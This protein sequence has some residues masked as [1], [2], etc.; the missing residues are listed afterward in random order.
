MVSEGEIFLNSQNLQCDWRLQIADGGIV[1]GLLNSTIAMADQ[2]AIMIGGGELR[3]FGDGTNN[4]KI[5]HESGYYAFNCY[6]GT[7]AADHVT[8]EYMNTNGVYIYNN[9]LI[10]NSSSL[11][12]C[13]FQN[14]EP[15]GTLLRLN[16]SQS[17]TIENADFPTNSWGSNYN[18]TK[19]TSAGEITLLYA[20][21]DFSGEGF[22]NDPN[23]L[24]NWEIPGFDLD[25][26]IY[27][28]G[29][30]HNGLMNFDL[31]SEIPL[32]QPYNISPWNYSGSESVSV[33]PGKTVDWVLVEL[34]DAP[35]AAL[36]TSGT[37]I[38]RQAALLKNNGYILDL[39]GTQ[40]LQF[41]QVINNQLFLVIWHR[42]HLAVMS[43][44][45]LVENG[46]VYS[47]N[48]STAE[49]QAYGDIDAHKEIAP[50]VYG[51]VGGDANRNGAVN[52][53]DKGFWDL[54]VGKRG[55]LYYDFNLDGQVDNQDK[56]DVLIRNYG[57][58]RQLPN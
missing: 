27:L 18:V 23:N 49:D 21:G 35:S 42:N 14:G 15:G 4:P 8:F 48:F 25:V 41:D 2:A 34:R 51:M 52:S 5:T 46:G 29:P 37:V 17:I 45:P 56:N 3:L 55:Y 54:H 50:G 58:Q 39:D 57:R 16:T 28:E 19:T 6:G 47:Y 53:Y 31:M 30:Y 7:V 11:N 22:E 1:S 44:Y 32:N 36:A 43:A 26:R 24:V 13:T 12:N 10:D 40:S 20:S 38:A 33:I 9:G